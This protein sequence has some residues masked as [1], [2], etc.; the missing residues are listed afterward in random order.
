MRA[1]FD[2]LEIQNKNMW[3]NKAPRHQLSQPVNFNQPFLYASCFPVQWVQMLAVILFTTKSIVS[4]L[5]R[6]CEEWWSQS[7]P[8][9]HLLVSKFGTLSE[10]TGQQQTDFGRHIAI[11]PP[12]VHFHTNAQIKLFNDVADNDVM[13]F[14]ATGSLLR[15]QP[16]CQD[17]QTCTLLG[18]NPV[19]GGVSLP[20]ASNVT[21][22]HDGASISHS[23]ERFLIDQIKVCKTAKKL[24]L[25]I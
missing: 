1:N 25:V 14:D 10:T 22:S 8:I 4:T 21:T 5:S 11:Y 24:A 23:L 20:V 19:E 13:Y 16:H 7:N 18:R 2:Y 15:R 3:I 12:A 9:H 17:Y 6:S